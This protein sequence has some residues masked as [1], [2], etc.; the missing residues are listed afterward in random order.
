M[1]FLKQGLIVVA[2][3]AFLATSTLGTHLHFCFDGREPPVSVRVS[4]G[5]IQYANQSQDNN[6]LDID[7]SDQVL[8]KPFKVDMPWITVPQVWVAS[9]VSNVELF[10][11]V[12]RQARV[13]LSPPRFLSPPLRG[14]PV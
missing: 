1:A 11:P 6:D 9:L 5:G 13:S 3:I 12:A 8:V 4:D 10:S 14:P 7:L 2:A